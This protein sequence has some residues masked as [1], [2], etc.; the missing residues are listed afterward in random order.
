MDNEKN[1]IMKLTTE[2]RGTDLTAQSVFIRI[3]HKGKHIRVKTGVILPNT[4]IENGHILAAYKLQADIIEAKRTQIKK[5][6]DLYNYEHNNLPSLDKLND[7]F[8]KAEAKPVDIDSMFRAFLNTKKRYSVERFNAYRLM[9]QHL[10]SYDSAISLERLTI[11]AVNNF[12]EYLEREG[13]GENTIGSY[14]NMLKAFLGYCMDNETTT[15]RRIDL[16]KIDEYGRECDIIYHPQHEITMLFNAKL[17]TEAQH[18]ARNLYLL[19]CLLGT[20][21]SD[22]NSSKWVME[23]DFIRLVPQKTE[24]T[25][26]VEV[27]LPIRPEVAKILSEYPDHKIPTF[28]NG[29]YNALIREVGSLAGI[30]TSIKLLKGRKGYQAGETV[31]KHE[32]MSS[33]VARATFIC[34]MLNNGISEAIVCRMAGIGSAALKHYAVIADETVKAASDKVYTLTGDMNQAK[35]R[36]A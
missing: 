9:M 17:N 13:L 26:A 21:H 15:L 12:A 18:H 28:S 2:L 34:L 1:R 31:I 5:F 33:H 29:D 16:A 7:R 24:T 35:L 23:R 14:L 20:R 19:Q 3:N 22:T 6:I 11:E 4:A 25:T 32:L 8:N 36:I 27:K 30:N 10:K